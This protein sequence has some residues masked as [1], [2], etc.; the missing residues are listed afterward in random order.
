MPLIFEI[1]TTVLL[2]LA[3]TQQVGN[4]SRM[5]NTTSIVNEDKRKLLKKLEQDI[6]IYLESGG[7]IK[8]I[9]VGDNTG[10]QPEIIRRRAKFR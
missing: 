7:T 9:R 1:L 2:P 4:K 5:T 6:K 10:F 3:L 8:K